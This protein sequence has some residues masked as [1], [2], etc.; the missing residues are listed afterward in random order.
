LV[1]A[2]DLTRSYLRLVGLKLNTDG[3]ARCALDFVACGG[4]SVLAMGII[5]IIFILS[6]IFSMLFMFRSMSVIL[7][8][9]YAQLKGLKDFD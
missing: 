7:A 5:R 2:L 1:L 4:I 9:E 3:A 6:W 8:T